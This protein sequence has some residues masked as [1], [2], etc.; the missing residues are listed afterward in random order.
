[1]LVNIYLS[2]GSLSDGHQVTTPFAQH[3]EAST[4]TFLVLQTDRQTDRQTD[5]IQNLDR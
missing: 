4:V 3:L 1:M 2:V 5:I